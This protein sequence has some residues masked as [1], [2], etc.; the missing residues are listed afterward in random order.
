MNSSESLR[1]YISLFLRGRIICLVLATVAAGCGDAESQAQAGGGGSVGAGACQTASL[2]TDPTQP[3]G[4]I[5]SLVAGGYNACAMLDDGSIR[6]WGD[7]TYG[8][9]GTGELAGGRYPAPAK[10]LPALDRVSI[11]SAHM[12]G[13]TLDRCVWC[14]G[15]NGHGQLGNPDA[16]GLKPLLLRDIHGARDV[17]ADGLASLALLRDGR[18]EWWGRR[19][20]EEADFAGVPAPWVV[21]VSYVSVGLGS[22]FA[23]GLRTDGHVEC[24]GENAYGQLGTGDNFSRDQPAEVVGLSAVTQLEVGPLSACAIRSDQSL[25]CWGGNIVGELGD[26]TKN[27]SSS[28]IKVALSGVERVAISNH[29][30]AIT[31]GGRLFCWG[32]NSFRQVGNGAKDDAVLTPWEITAVKGARAIAVGSDFTCALLGDHDVRCWGFNNLFSLGDGTGVSSPTPVQVVWE[33]PP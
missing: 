21:N 26:G 7:N 2:V 31:S 12:C 14:W 29:P 5:A 11:G 18:V 23:C 32:D 24:W 20:L 13:L 33:E 8:Q 27:D 9:L 4:H 19:G 22:G 3:I 28:P 17:V 16:G 15:D 30:C 25:W 10:G 1:Y 6:C